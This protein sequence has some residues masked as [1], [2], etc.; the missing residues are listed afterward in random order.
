MQPPPLRRSS[1][2]PPVFNAEPERLKTLFKAAD[3]GDPR[4]L[5]QLCADLEGL[6]FPEPANTRSGGSGGDPVQAAL[7]RYCDEQASKRIVGQTMTSDNG[8]SLA[9]GQVHERVAGWILEG[10]AGDLAE[11]ITRDLVEPYVR[12]NF[13]AD[14]PIPKIAAVI[15]SSE[16]REFQ[17]RA[18]EVLVPLG[19]RV[20]Q[21][22]VRDLAG[23]P[24]PAEGAE[25]L[26]PPRSGAPTGG[27]SRRR[28]GAAAGLPA[29]LSEAELVALARRL[30]VAPAVAAAALPQR[31]RAARGLGERDTKP[32]NRF[33][34]DD[35]EDI[36]D[37]DAGGAAGENWRA[38]L[39]PFVE[40]AEAV[41]EE[42]SSFDDYLR[43]LGKR[44]VDGDKLVRNL[45]TATMQLRGVGDGTD[46]VE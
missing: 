22:I 32:G 27:A 24:E 25:L 16:R 2:K 6:E 1:R 35:H 38:D 8:S 10:D 46:E 17:L 37:R 4:E 5:Q 11:T 28:S 14:A 12:L 21:S 33:A 9:Q 7:A 15:E 36:V 41:A 23:F 30:K 18:L 42:A 20:E 40:A 29:G 34:A 45:A 19:L 44:T 31:L 3:D 39:Q 43:K 26:T 13:G